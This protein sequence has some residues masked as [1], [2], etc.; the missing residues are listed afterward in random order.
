MH[1]G[2]GLMADT[3][4]ATSYELSAAARP[5]WIG[6]DRHPSRAACEYAARKTERQ[7]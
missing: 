3:G 2:C 5:F 4:S 7:P 1:V 6:S